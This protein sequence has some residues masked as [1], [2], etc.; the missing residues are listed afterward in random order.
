MI[1]VLM[2]CLGNIC[3]S[4]M[5]EYLFKA[6]VERQGLNHV[7]A[8]ASAGT[9]GW[10]NGEDMH[11]ETAKVLDKHHIKHHDFVSSQ[12]KSKDLNQYDYFIAM[13]DN[14]LANLTTLLGSH[15]DKIFKITD[16]IPQSQYDHVPDPWHTGNFNETEE[17]LLSGSLALLDKIRQEHQL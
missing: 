3:R 16:L 14:N 7:I 13:D 8:V 1:N 11:V 17:I 15:P 2:V 10:H 12:V 4:P 6:E 5:A 9:S